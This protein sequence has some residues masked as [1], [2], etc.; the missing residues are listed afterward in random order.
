MQTTVTRPSPETI[1]LAKTLVPVEGTA[2][3]ACRGPIEGEVTS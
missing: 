2:V 3:M 1:T